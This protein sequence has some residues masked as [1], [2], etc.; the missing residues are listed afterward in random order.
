MKTA[1]VIL[2]LLA[3]PLFAVHNNLTAPTLTWEDVKNAFPS[4]TYIDQTGKKWKIQFHSP[5]KTLP[6]NRAKKNF[7]VRAFSEKTHTYDTSGIQYA[8]YD[9]FK[10]KNNMETRLYYLAFYLM[11]LRQEK[12]HFFQG[13]SMLKERKN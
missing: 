8:T 2:C 7:E 12:D 4:K 10:T 3:Q 11:E 1:A 13:N 9:V 5:V 6:D